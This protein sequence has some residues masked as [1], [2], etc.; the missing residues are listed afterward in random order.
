MGDSTWLSTTSGCDVNH[1]E[2]ML[3]TGLMFNIGNQG[4][5]SSSSSTDLSLDIDNYFESDAWLNVG[6]NSGYNSESVI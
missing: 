5:G 2:P 4:N 1:R 6:S 3:C